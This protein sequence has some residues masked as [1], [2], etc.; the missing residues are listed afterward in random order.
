MKP[1]L[2]ADPAR[3]RLWSLPSGPPPAELQQANV[4]FFEA[5][6]PELGSNQRPHGL[7]PADAVDPR[8][9]V[10]GHAQLERFAGLQTQAVAGPRFEPA[11]SAARGTDPA[12]SPRVG[13]D[14]RTSIDY[15]DRRE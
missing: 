1:H 12:R 5:L 13:R 15:D 7:T 11:T 3:R 8:W 9:G 2:F 14:H 6:V 10:S 4:E